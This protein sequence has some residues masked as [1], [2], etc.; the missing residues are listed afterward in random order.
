MDLDWDKMALWCETNGN[1]PG[2]KCVTCYFSPA[3]HGAVCPKE[4]MDEP[5]C[6]CP[7]VKHT[8][9]DTLKFIR[10]ESVLAS[11]KNS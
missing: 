8:I 11:I 7:K 6:A 3:C 9:G 2:K 4:W 1:D 10:L 5:E